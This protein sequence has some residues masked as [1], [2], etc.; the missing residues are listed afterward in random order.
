MN[1]FEFAQK[2]VDIAT[3][4][5]TT[6]GKGGY[7]QKLTAYWKGYFKLAYKDNRTNPVISAGIDNA[8]SNT[9]IYDC[10]C[11]DKA[12]IN[13][14]KGYTK[15]PCP[16]ITIEAML[17][18]CT[19]ISTDMNDIEIGEFLV[20]ADCS[21]CGVYVGVFNNKR[22]AVECTERWDNGVQLVDIERVERTEGK[23]AWKR[24]GKLSKYISYSSL[25]EEHADDLERAVNQLVVAR[26]GMK[27]EYIA[28][29]QRCLNDYGYG[30]AEDG[31]FGSGT[32]SAVRDYQQKNF[33]VAD[34]IV[35]FNTIS[36]LIK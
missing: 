32:E 8:D 25:A 21:H 14:N 30:L 4:E 2:L 29:I 22:M 7:G 34:G 28:K 20:N 24:H 1:N 31:I 13:G 33:L 16:D 27:G 5:K 9:S 10:V 12:T 15:S 18:E 36:A 17:N 3:K 23:Y 19:D 11:L 26:K 35:G 6:Y